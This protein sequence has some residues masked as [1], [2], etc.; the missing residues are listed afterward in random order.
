MFVE[1]SGSATTLFCH[2]QPI[3][4]ILALNENIM[5]GVIQK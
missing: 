5:A 4:S 2:G 3:Q 1:I